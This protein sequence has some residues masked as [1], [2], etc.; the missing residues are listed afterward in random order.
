MIIFIG[1][2]WIL[3]TTGHLPKYHMQSEGAVEAVLATISP[4]EDQRLK[5]AIAMLKL[6]K[7]SRESYLLKSYLCGE[8]R[9]QLGQQTS[10][11]LV[12]M[13]LKHPNWLLS[14][15]GKGTVTFTEKID[16][17]SPA[18]KEKAVFGIDGSS[19][20]S[21][22]NGTPTEENVIR[23]FFQLNIKS[24]ESSLP[25]D[26]VEQLHEGIRVSDL[27][28][29]NSV[30]STFSDYAIEESERVMTKP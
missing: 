17:L 14:L 21:L 28:E 12:Q 20:L 24:L 18:C 7:E 3:Q 11:D 2:G 26:T 8:E 1:T 30:L 5:E 29:Y 9:I 22:F 6:M 27:E 16:D 13:Q 19:N 25:K 10:D 23:T 15:D 4:E